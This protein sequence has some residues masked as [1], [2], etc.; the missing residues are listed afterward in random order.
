MN[1]TCFCFCVLFCC[2]FCFCSAGRAHGGN[3]CRYF[4]QCSHRTCKLIGGAAMTRRRRLQYVFPPNLVPKPSHSQPNQG[5]PFP[6]YWNVN[7][8]LQMPS[9]GAVPSSGLRHKSC[10]LLRSLGVAQAPQ[11]I[12]ALGSQTRAWNSPTACHPKKRANRIDPNVL[13]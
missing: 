13:A 7:T 3:H 6:I 10:D 2:W 12:A 8:L 5:L 11:E 1:S 4:S 9:C